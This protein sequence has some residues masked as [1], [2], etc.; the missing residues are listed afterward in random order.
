MDNEEDE[1]SEEKKKGRANTDNWNDKKVIK[2][3]V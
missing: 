3:V 1:V 2:D